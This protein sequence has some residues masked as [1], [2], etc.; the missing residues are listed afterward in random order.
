M[1]RDNLPRSTP[2]TADAKQAVDIDTIQQHGRELGILMDAILDAL[3][4]LVCPDR[5]TSKIH[6]KVS[7]FVRCAAGHARVLTQLSHEAEAQG[8]SM[9][10]GEA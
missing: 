5:K 7:Y 1:M 3:D 2:A 10:G 6:D 9:K 4:G 8:S